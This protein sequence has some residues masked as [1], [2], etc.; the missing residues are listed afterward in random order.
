ME[1]LHSFLRRHSA[2]KPVVA[3]RNVSFFLRLKHNPPIFCGFPVQNTSCNT[4]AE[5]EFRLK[6]YCTSDRTFEKDFN[7]PIFSHY[8]ELDNVEWSC[9]DTSFSYNTIH[10]IYVLLQSFWSL[11]VNFTHKDVLH[12]LEHLSQI[13]TNVGKCRVSPT[14]LSFFFSLTIW[15][16]RSAG[17]GPEQ[18]LLYTSS[19]YKCHRR[20]QWTLVI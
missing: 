9:W 2:G 8:C 14:L 7:R 19:L 4:Q 11:I 13:H 3:S 10:L 6:T 5:L 16:R 1:F 17:S 12:E 18:A 15:R 20:N